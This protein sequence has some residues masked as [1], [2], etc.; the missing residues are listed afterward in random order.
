MVL[1]GLAL[2]VAVVFCAYWGWVAVWLLTPFEEGEFVST[3]DRVLV[4][5]LVVSITA[6]FLYATFGL[7]RYM[8]GRPIRRQVLIAAYVLGLLA[9]PV[10]WA[11]VL[12]NFSGG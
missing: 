7:I 4:E 11:A 12:A 6:C 2:A 3:R 1:C 8:R 9:T 10:G 5:A